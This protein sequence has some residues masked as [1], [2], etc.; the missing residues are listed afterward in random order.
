MS[1]IYRGLANK[2]LLSAVHAVTETQSPSEAIQKI[3]NAGYHTKYRLNTE[4]H[5]SI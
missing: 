2:G 1:K 4:K 3:K 5:N